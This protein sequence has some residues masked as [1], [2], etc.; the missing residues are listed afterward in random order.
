[1]THWALIEDAPE[2]VVVRTC[3]MDKDGFRND[4]RLKRRGRLWFTPDDAMYV[5]YTPT[6][7]APRS[8][9][10]QAHSDGEKA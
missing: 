3:I 4:Q 2:D 5:Y 6:H 1:M 7:W 8:V 9:G 10:E